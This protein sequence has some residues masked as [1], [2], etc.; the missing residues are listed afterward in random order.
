MR[1]ILEKRIQ[2]QSLTKDEAKNT[3]LDIGQGKCNSYQVAAFL[4]T[5][6]M[7]PITVD[8][9]SGFR[10]ALL[11]LCIA[12]DLSDYDTIDLC[13]TGGDGKDTF[14]ISTLASFVTAGAGVAVAKHGNYGVSSS[15]GSSNVMEHL[16]VRF[17]NQQDFLKNCIEKAGICVLHAPLFHPAMMHVAPIRRHLGLKTFFNMLGPLVNPSKPN[18]QMVGVFNLELQRIYRYVL[19]ETNQQYSILHALDGYDEISL[20]G[21][22]KVVSNNGSATINAAS[23]DLDKLEPSQIGGGD[24]VDA[25][26]AIFMGVLEGKSTEAQKQVVC[27]NAGI[28]IATAKAFDI[29]EGYAHAV[30]SIESG[31]ALQ[32]LQTLQQLSAK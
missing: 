24:S 31:K 22:T 10:A 14:N 32:A 2:N 15:C 25:A 1:A 27:A 3:L 29:Q 5:Y 13:G 21:N 8:E 30:E 4:T 6:M 19:E 7:R 28:A 20:T 17:S 26:A 23:F 16:G 11:D 12:I 18:K 9:L